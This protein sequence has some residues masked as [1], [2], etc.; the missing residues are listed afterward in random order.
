[1]RGFFM[2]IDSLE[3]FVSGQIEFIENLT[4]DL[5]QDDIQIEKFTNPPDTLENQA[6]NCT[7]TELT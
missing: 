5:L 3:P 4:K 1:M 7:S 6:D 2:D